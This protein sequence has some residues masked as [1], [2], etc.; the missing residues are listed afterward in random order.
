MCVRTLLGVS[1]MDQKKNSPVGIGCDS[2]GGCS[3]GPWITSQSPTSIAGLNSFGY[4][5]LDNVMFSP[6]FDQNTRAFFDFVIKNM[7]N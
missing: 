7:C 1:E 4:R 2:T 6:Y 3:G 5:G